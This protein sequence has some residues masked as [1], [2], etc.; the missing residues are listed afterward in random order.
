[1][2]SSILIEEG[3]TVGLY[4]SPHLQNYNERFKTN[5]KDISDKDFAEIVDFVAEKYN[6]LNYNSFNTFE[7]L[8]VCAF[9]YFFDKKVDILILE[10]GLGGKMDATNIIENPVLSIITSIGMDHMNLLGN[11]LEEIAVEKGGIIKKNCPVVLYTQLEIVYNV[12]KD[13]CYKNNSN[14][15]YSHNEKINIL[16]K[17]IHETEFYVENDYVLYENVLLKMIGA[18]QLKNASLALTAC[19]ALVNYGIKLSE[20]GILNGLKKTSW[21]GRMEIICNNPIVFFDGAHNIDGFKE[22]K[23]SIKLYFADKKVNL[24]IGVLADKEYE[25]MVEIIL[26]YINK[27]IV[28]EPD[29][30]RALEAK[31]F[32]KVFIDL[33]KEVNHTNINALD[34]LKYALDITKKNEVLCCCGSL[35]LIGQLRNYIKQI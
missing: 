5:N 6:T 18:Y 4:T 35:Y 21:Y 17:N 26:P 34:A 22:L 23:Q 2:L 13:I 31:A 10:T 27:V 11:T 19:K 20:N 3:Y 16:N 29:S 30:Y 28:T 15:Y 24:L 33:G 25:E 8:T 7:F 1:M 14:L 9:K 12:I 32:E